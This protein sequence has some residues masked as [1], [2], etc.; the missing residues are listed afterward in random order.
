[1]CAR[2]VSATAEEVAPSS[3]KELL[4]AQPRK[5]GS[6][7]HSWSQSKTARMLSSGVAC[8]SA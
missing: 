6:P 8:A 4:K 5:S 3:P 7:N 2:A 1:M